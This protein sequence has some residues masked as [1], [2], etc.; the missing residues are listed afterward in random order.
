[1]IHRGRTFQLVNLNEPIKSVWQGAPPVVLNVTVTPNVQFTELGPV[2]SPDR[3]ES[4]VL[5]SSL[6]QDLQE[7]IRIAVNAI[8]SST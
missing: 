6:P 1:M 2:E 7:R 5:V 8:R 4:Y 3:N